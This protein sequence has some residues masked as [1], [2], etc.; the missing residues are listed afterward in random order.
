MQQN[1]NTNNNLFGSISYSE[2]EKLFLQKR[3]DE[4]LDNEEVSKRQGPGGGEVHYL[5]TWRAIQLANQVLGFNGWSSS[6][7]E[8][9]QD[10]CD[11]QTP[12]RYSC[13]FSAIV[14]ITLKD[15][16]YH[17]DIGYGQSENQKSKAVALANGKKNAVSD[18]LKRA[19]RNFGNQLGLTIYDKDHIKVLKRTTRQIGQPV[20]QKLS[21]PNFIE[22]KSPQKN[23]TESIQQKEIKN[24]TIQNVQTVEVKKEIIE[25]TS[26]TN[27]T[28]LIPVGINKRPPLKIPT[29]QLPNS[30]QVNVPITTN[31]S[32]PN[33]TTNSPQQ[34]PILQNNVSGPLIPVGI[35]RDLPGKSIPN[36]PKKKKV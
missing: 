31:N 5:E 17:E 3:L 4:K 15:G 34:S 13:G 28:P 23:S 7:A 26:V 11:Q 25:E 35:K 29:P 1:K 14:R 19:L 6:I 24:E 30:P 9:T 32:P 16:S 12:G 21:N 33:L 18:A 10:F 2:E 22:S 8:I 27:S 36:D 20:K